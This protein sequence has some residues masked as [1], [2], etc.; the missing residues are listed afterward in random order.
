MKIKLSLLLLLFF[1][2]PLFSQTNDFGLWGTI[3][4]EKKWNKQYSFSYTQEVRF[5]DNAT[6]IDKTFSEVKINYRINKYFNTSLGYRFSVCFDDLELQTYL[7]H[8]F[9]WD[10]NIRYKINNW[11]INYRTRFV[12]EFERMQSSTNGIIP[13]YVNRNKIQ[14]TYNIP[15]N[16]FSIAVSEEIY[17]L[18]HSFGEEGFN[19]NRNALSINYKLNTI[20]EIGV[21]YM[22]E[23]RF[24]TYKHSNNYILG[25]EYSYNL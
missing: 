4:L 8:R 9:Y 1:S 11:R 10:G 20:Q 16:P 23:Q 21:F 6:R 12:Q 3:A 14:C 7:K 22:I 24:N 5:F 2:I 25:I 17:Y 15:N 18:F 13:K 19:K